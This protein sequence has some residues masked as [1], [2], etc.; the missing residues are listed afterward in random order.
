V[1]VVVAA[2]G[3]HQLGELVVECGAVEQT[4]ERIDFSCTHFRVDDSHRQ[5]RS[6]HHIGTHHDDDARAGHPHN[7]VGLS[8]SRREHTDGHRAHRRRQHQQSAV[9]K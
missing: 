5:A 2:A 8:Q 7:G 1:A 6:D 3:A 4:G 9:V